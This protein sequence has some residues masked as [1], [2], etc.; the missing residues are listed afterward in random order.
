MRRSPC[1]TNSDP[2]ALTLG[3]PIAI[4]GVA[5]LATLKAFDAVCDQVRGTKFGDPK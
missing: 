1:L 5:N 3:D 2:N 4:G